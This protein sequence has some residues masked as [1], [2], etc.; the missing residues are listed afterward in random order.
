MISRGSSWYRPALV[1]VIYLGLGAAGLGWTSLRG[2]PSLWQ[3]PGRQDPW[4]F[5]GILVGLLVGLG[6]VFASR[7]AFFRFEW[8]RALHRDFRALLSPLGDREI[9]V[10]A[11]A[12][13]IGEEMFFRGAMLPVLGLVG[14][15]AVFALLHI[16][17]PPR[18][19]HLPWTIS[20]FVA[21]VV[22]GALYLWTGDLTGAVV[23]HFTVNFLNLRHI[24]QYDLR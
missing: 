6:I 19:R 16:G 17:L 1:M 10:L 18:A 9:V 13:S 2:Q 11:A 23:A 15:S 4:V 21:G 12:S 14:S 7:M 24:A 22:F 20:S 5:T 8:A 3:V